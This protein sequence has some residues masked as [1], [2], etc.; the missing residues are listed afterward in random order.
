MVELDHLYDQFLDY[1]FLVIILASVFSI[2][3]L[4][5]AIKS[6]K[7][8]TNPP[9]P[10][11][12]PA[13]PIIG[14]LH[15][16]GKLP[17]HDF[18]KVSGRYG[19]IVYLRFGN[20][21]SLLVSS[22]EIAKECLKTNE[23]CFLNRPQRTNI[24]YLTY[25]N[26]DFV[27][28]PYGPFWKFMKKLTVSKLLGASMMEFYRP[29]R[30]EEI[31][32]LIKNMRKM[33]NDGEKVDVGAQLM[34]LTNNIV[35]RMAL[36]QKCAKNDDDAYEM[37]HV[38]NEMSDLGGKLNVQDFIWFCKK[39]DLQGFGKRLKEVRD[40]Y[41]RLMGKIIEEHVEAKRKRKEDT[42]DEE[43]NKD[44][45]D[46]LLDE[47]ED[48][49]SKI[50]LTKEN[51]RA[52]IMNIFG[53][54]TET[55]SVTMEWAISELMTHPTAMGKARKEIE[56]VVGNKR[57]VEETDLPNLPYIRAIIKE[58]L[59]LHPGGAFTARES[60]KD[61]TIGG[62]HVPANTRLFVNTWAINRD[63]AHWDDPHRFIPERFMMEEKKDVDVRGQ[64]F[65]LIPFGSGKRGCPGVN[66]A[67]LTIPT[68]VA[69]LVQ[70]FDWNGVV[71]LDEGFGLSLPKARPLV[72]YPVVRLDPF[73]QVM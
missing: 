38:I 68:T 17:H 36:K 23:S 13:L 34:G 60:S 29:I 10:P 18:C 1:N 70:C 56:E 32:L 39:F 6:F 16:I 59:R 19:P 58:T 48:E 12:P 4:G 55:Q 27:L 31:G 5:R 54:G 26:S 35:S 37:R 53:G 11:S 47:Y 67:L 46:M 22:A 64:H 14:H 42:N 25:G 63:P 45:L 65:E 15:L 51:I 73:P 43:V 30:G 61:C 3:S 62:Y 7:A 21:H 28:A 66:L 9:L 40:R 44:I 72:C 8:Q 33:A 71:D 2:I 24:Q 57:I 69:A 49:K 50:K 20:K 41:D 52:Y